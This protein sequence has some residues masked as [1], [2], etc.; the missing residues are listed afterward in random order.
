MRI[1]KQETFISEP[2]APEPGS[3]DTSMMAQGGPGIP[4]VF[5]W[6]G[7]RYEVLGVTDTWTS[8]EPGKGMDRGYTYLRKHFYRV[9]TTSGEVMILQFDRKPQGSRGRQR[10]SLFSIETPLEDKG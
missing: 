6:R 4:R 9:K 1:R 8:R 7:R 5:T 10:W 3:F 2:I